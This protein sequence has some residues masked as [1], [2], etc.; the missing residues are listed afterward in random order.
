MHKVESNNVICKNCG[1]LEGRH[2]KLNGNTYEVKFC[3]FCG[4]KML[5]GEDR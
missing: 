1:H 3:P 2:F 4:S 5:S